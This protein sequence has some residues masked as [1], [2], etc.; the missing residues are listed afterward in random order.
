[1]DASSNDVDAWW[2][3]SGASN[4]MTGSRLKFKEIDES[5]RERVK[6]GGG[7]TALIEGKG[8]ILVECKSGEL[9]HLTEV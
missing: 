3:D 7:S 2:L 5:I 9:L 4:H 1:M 8:S 6:L